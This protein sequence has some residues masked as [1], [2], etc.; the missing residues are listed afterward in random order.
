MS[1]RDKSKKYH[2]EV[3]ARLKEGARLVAERGHEPEL[4]MTP[5]DQA[6]ISQ[7]VFTH[8]VARHTNKRGRVV[9]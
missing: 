3:K 9:R 5:Q 4:Q 8:E 1:R 7:A 6:E 2:D